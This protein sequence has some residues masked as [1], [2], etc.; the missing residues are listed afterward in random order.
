MRSCGIPRFAAFRIANSLNA[1]VTIG[2]L[3][4]PIFSVVMQ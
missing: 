4:M 3:G 2:T 1:L